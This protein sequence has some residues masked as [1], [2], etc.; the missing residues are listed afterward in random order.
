MPLLYFCRPLDSEK[1]IIYVKT[2]E[3]DNIGTMIYPRP[4]NW[5][6]I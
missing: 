4:H 3:V 6:G 5:T 1:S 2:F